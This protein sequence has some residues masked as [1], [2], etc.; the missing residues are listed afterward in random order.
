[1]ST[2]AGYQLS[3]FGRRSGYRQPTTDY[4]LLISL[5]TAA[6]LHMAALLLVP[7]AGPDLP[8]AAGQRPGNISIEIDLRSARPSAV[9]SR[10]QPQASPP[11]HQDH[12]E[13]AT[14]DQESG[15]RG[16]EA[17]SPIPDPESPI[18]GSRPSASSLTQGVA[19]SRASALASHHIIY[20]S[21]A[22]HEDREGIVVVRV[23]V[24]ASGRAGKV[25][26]VTSSG[27]RD[28]DEAAL[29]GIRRG[30]HRP[31]LAGGR[32]VRSVREF[33]V[34]FELTGVKAR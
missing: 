17:P 28:L 16:Q 8:A 22:R 33:R 26:L 12:Q 29:H 32:P 31:A 15:T 10:A 20:P 18:P 21:R 3:V 34:R 27:H 1:M 14:G 19:G 11:R 23:E 9:E 2:A 24:L 25:D 4:R 7:E 13:S 30:R 6:A 5:A